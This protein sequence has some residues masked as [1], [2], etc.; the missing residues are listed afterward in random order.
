MDPEEL[1]IFF[2]EFEANIILSKI[3]FWVKLFSG[4]YSAA[5]FIGITTVLFKR[6]AISKQVKT[7]KEVVDDSV[8]YDIPKTVFQ[9]RWEKIKDLLKSENQ[10][11]YRAAII[12]ADNMLDE[13]L[14]KIGYKGGNLGDRLKKLDKGKLSNI[15]D[16]WG[17]RKLRNSF[18]HDPHHKPKRM[19]IEEAIKVYEDSL[20]DLG[21]L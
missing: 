1:E 17:A 4:I 11:D 21:A 13:T 16:L 3:L 7:V 10:S 12:D 5:C 15:E 6:G 9:Q 20:K 2:E 14:E 18:V 19:Q 8:K